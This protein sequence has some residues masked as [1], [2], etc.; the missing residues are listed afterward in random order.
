MAARKCRS[1]CSRRIFSCI[2]RSGRGGI[3]S[4]EAAGSMRYWHAPSHTPHGRAAGVRS[5]SMSILACVL[6]A[7][8]AICVYA[9][10][11]HVFAARH[12]WFRAVHLTFAALALITAVHAT[13]HIAVYNAAGVAQY[14]AA[15]RYSNLSGSL[16]MPLVPWLV[17]GYF[18]AGSRWVAIVMSA[19][20]ALSGIVYELAAIG[21]DSRPAPLLA[22]IT[23]PWGETATIHRLP[24]VPVAAWIFWA[25]SLL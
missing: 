14:V 11:A 18:A 7:V 8:A 10:I 16:A 25:V 23:L 13:S 22:Q 9:C 2:A 12:P 24:A 3:R 15:E 6:A 5:K 1:C 19:F 17:Q 4:R 21:S 20:Y